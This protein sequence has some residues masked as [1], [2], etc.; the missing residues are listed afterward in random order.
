M[1]EQFL[2][3]NSTDIL[4]KSASDV[5]WVV[6]NKLHVGNYSKVHD[7]KVSQIVLGVR[8]THSHEY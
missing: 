1:V 2:E 4:F 7:D 3:D 8:K 5:I 6:Y